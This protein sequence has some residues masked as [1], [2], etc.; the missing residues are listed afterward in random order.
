MTLGAKDAGIDVLFA[1]ERCPAAAATYRQNFPNIELY[2]GDIRDVS[3]LPKPPPGTKTIVFGG[4]PCQGFSTSNQRT[5]NADNQDNWMYRELIRVAV[6]WKPDWIVIEN[7]K[8]IR[9]TLGGFFLREIETNLRSVGYT[10]TTTSPD[11][12]RT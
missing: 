2:V 11:I 12:A 1:V 6:I 8:G 7:V 10:T 3:S 4:P 5:R 9:E